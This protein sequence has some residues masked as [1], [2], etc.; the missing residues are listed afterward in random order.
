MTTFCMAP[1]INNKDM[2]TCCMAPLMNNIDMTTCCMASLIN[3][4]D[5]TTCCMAPLMNNIDTTTCCMAHLNNIDMTTCCMAPLMNVEV[6]RFAE[7]ALAP[8]TV[9]CFCHRPNLNKVT[10]VYYFSKNRDGYIYVS[11]IRT[12]LVRP[13]RVGVGVFSAVERIGGTGP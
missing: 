8:P 12:F 4:I 9:I 6:V 1:L 7:G 11:E 10:N 2:T 5:V 3:N 13:K